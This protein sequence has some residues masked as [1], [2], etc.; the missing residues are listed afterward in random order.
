MTGLDL[1]SFVARSRTVIDSSPP[2]TERETR[3][4][5]V[6]PFL[7]TLGW[8]VRAD[9]TTDVSIE[10]VRI[11]YVLS[12]DSIPAVFVAIEPYGEPLEEPRAR[13]LLEAMSWTG[14][15]R[16]VYTNGREFFLLAGTIDVDRLACRLP[17]LADHESS[18]AHFSRDAARRRLERHSREDV[19]RQLALER[20]ALVES[21]VDQVTSTLR[22]GEAY[23][24]EIQSATNRF[25]DRLVV[26]FSGDEN[27]RFDPEPEAVSLRFTEPTD[28]DDGH[29]PPETGTGQDGPSPEDS[30]PPTIDRS[31]DGETQ[32]AE[33]ES[34]D[35]ANDRTDVGTH[36]Q[37]D[38]ADG[39]ASED[40]EETSVEGDGEYVARFFSE[41]GSIGAI[42]HSRSD[43]ALV[44]AAEYLFER[45][46]SGIRLPWGPEDG[47]TVVNDEPRRADS[48]PMDADRQLSNGLYLETGGDVDDHSARVEALTA[49]AGLR[50]LLTGD[51]NQS[52]SGD[53]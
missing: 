18:L 6:E 33:S 40:D 46:L 38:S 47:D 27:D 30:T 13:N 5:I 12:A 48:T 8:D 20:D 43:R 32:Y 3:T 41:R 1:L 37:S 50:V 52:S 26:S 23:D 11:E 15:D 53:S 28:S 4:W 34:A 19:A 17:S 44:H 7:E 42:G 45:G 49:R 24:G 25:L 10:D 39:N 22:N 31:D 29:L 14:V 35:Q 51:W 2:T 16:T 21:I 36:E 9:S